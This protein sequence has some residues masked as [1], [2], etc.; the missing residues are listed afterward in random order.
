MSFSSQ[1]KEELCRTEPARC[2]QLAE[3]LG[4]V[5][6]CNTCSAAEVRVITESR[7]EHCDVD[8]SGGACDG[9]LVIDGRRGYEH[10]PNARVAYRGDRAR[11]M[12]IMCEAFAG[13][14]K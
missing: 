1:V 10:A 5:L 6:Y 12:E 14:P 13:G 7:E 2:C 4:V 9:M 11:F 3:C 8:F